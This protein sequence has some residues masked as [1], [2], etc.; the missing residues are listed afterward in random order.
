MSASAPSCCADHVYATARACAS[1][2]PLTHDLGCL[3]RRQTT[4]DA[5]WYAVA[6]DDTC[7]T[8]RRRRSSC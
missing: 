1:I 7:A 8:R 6:A 4:A 2:S 5:R 3:A